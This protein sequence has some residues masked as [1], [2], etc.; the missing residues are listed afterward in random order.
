MPFLVTCIFTL[1]AGFPQEKSN[2]FP[3][4]VLTVWFDRI[5]RDMFCKSKTV[6][7]HQHNATVFIIHLFFKGPKILISS[8]CIYYLPTNDHTKIL[9][10][11]L[12]N[13]YIKC[14]TPQEIFDMMFCVLHF[15]LAHY[16][17]EPDCSRSRDR[18]T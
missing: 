11:L 5:H 4:T 9:Q 17:F 14:G 13:N 16:V 8:F 2:K 15:L 3:Q 12:Q 7:S 10:F 18:N 6:F 1:L